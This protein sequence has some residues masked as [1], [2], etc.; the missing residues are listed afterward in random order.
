[1]ECRK[2]GNKLSDKAIICNCCGE[3][4]GTRTHMEIP[5]VE[6]NKKSGVGFKEKFFLVIGV[7]FWCSVGYYF[8]SNHVEKTMAYDYAKKEVQNY[9]EQLGA[10]NCCTY[11]KYDSDYINDLGEEEQTLSY[12]TLDYEKYAIE[13]PVQINFNGN[14]FS[15][16]VKCYA[17]VYNATS[18]TS[19]I[20]DHVHILIPDKEDYKKSQQNLIDEF[21][22]QLDQ[23]EQEQEDYFNSID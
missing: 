6:Y 4:V 20:P 8:Y 2:C 13:V 18:K 3:S 16:N 7:V 11:L 21:N 10:E 14:S 17:W 22:Q 12:G 15:R 23:Y 5:D 1:M 19:L 9:M